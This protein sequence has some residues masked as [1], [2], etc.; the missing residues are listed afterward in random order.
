[1]SLENGLPFAV[2]PVLYPFTQLAGMDLVVEGITMPAYAVAE[3]PPP[4][5]EAVAPPPPPAY[6]APYYPPRKP[7]N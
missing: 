6:V 4:P 7:R 3:A 1:V 5:P 2:V